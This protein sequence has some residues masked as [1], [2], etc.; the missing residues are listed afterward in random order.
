MPS[1]GLQNCFDK[2]LPLGTHHVSPILCQISE[3]LQYAFLNKLLGHFIEVQKSK[4][5]QRLGN[6]K[7]DCIVLFFLQDFEKLGVNLTP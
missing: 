2:S 7:S 1:T 3:H 5:F 6:L 4:C